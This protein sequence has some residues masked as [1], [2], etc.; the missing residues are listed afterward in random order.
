M[1]FSE[2][3]RREQQFRET[4]GPMRLRLNINKI[5]EGPAVGCRQ[6]QTIRQNKKWDKGDNDED[7]GKNVCVSRELENLEM[8]QGI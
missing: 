6:W 3:Q 2:K 5:S 7:N 8:Y 4:Q 1:Y